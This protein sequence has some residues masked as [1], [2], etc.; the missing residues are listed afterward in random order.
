MSHFYPE[1]LY[2]GKKYAVTSLSSGYISIC[3][4]RMTQDPRLLI[5]PSSGRVIFF[6]HRITM[7]LRHLRRIGCSDTLLLVNTAVNNYCLI[8]N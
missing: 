3:T 8:N 4:W 2:F 7:A 6:L 1:R 5:H